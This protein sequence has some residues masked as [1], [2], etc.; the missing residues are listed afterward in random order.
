[1]SNVVRIDAGNQ[2]RELVVKEFNG[3]R[4]VTFRDVDELHQRPEGT[5]RKR[6]N[7][8]R[9]HFVEGE[10]FFVI[11]QPS[12]IRTLGLTRPQGGL[13]EKVVLLTESGYLMLVKSFTDDLAWQVQR[14]LV[15]NY[16]RA[17]EIFTNQKY[18]RELEMEARVRNARA[19][20]ARLLHAMAKEFSSVLSPEAVQA[21]LSH[22][23][24]VLT[25][26]RIIPL[27][28][29][30]EPLFTAEEIAAELG[31]SANKVGRIAN[32]YGLKT[33]ENGVWLLDKAKHSDK[34]V[35]SFRYNNKGRQEVIDAFGKECADEEVRI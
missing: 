32:K 16:F 8:N 9:K 5:A 27:P 26:E 22:A 23:T 6:F 2:S 12:E 25:G 18:L 13:P 4:V 11:D 17:K 7:D 1:M 34:Q 33:A 35:R 29:V 10:D 19:R 20:E 21:M 28:Q 14:A 15:R 3:Q 30:D 31:I 24:M